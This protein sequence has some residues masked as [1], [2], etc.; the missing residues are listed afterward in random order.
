MDAILI[1]G[2]TRLFPV[3]LIKVVHHQATKRSGCCSRVCCLRY[4]KW[5]FTSFTNFMNRC[6]KNTEEDQE[7]KVVRCKQWLLL[8]RLA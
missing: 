2:S 3:T 4:A 6:E 1:V 5:N 7:V 8:M